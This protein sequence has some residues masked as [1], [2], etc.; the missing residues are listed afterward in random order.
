MSLDRIMQQQFVITCIISLVLPMLMLQLSR[1]FVTCVDVCFGDVGVGYHGTKAR[2]V[3][4]VYIV[5]CLTAR[6]HDSMTIVSDNYNSQCWDEKDPSDRYT[7]HINLDSLP[8]SML[9]ESVWTV[10]WGGCLPDSSGLF[11]DKAE[12]TLHSI[13]ARSWSVSL[14]LALVLIHRELLTC[15]AASP[16]RFA[17]PP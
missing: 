15:S 10:C 14:W 3:V 7:S 13:S 1:Y 16:P 8:I 9:R 17:S 12:L 11:S 4:V 6:Q 2:A 5:T